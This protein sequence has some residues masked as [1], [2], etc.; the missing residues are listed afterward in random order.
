MVQKIGRSELLQ[1]QFYLMLATV[2]SIPLGIAINR[3]LTTA[4]VIVTLTAVD[5]TTINVKIKQNWLLMLPL[6]IGLVNLFGLLYTTDMKDGMSML[7]RSAFYGVLPLVV[8]LIPPDRNQTKRLINT[9]ILACLAVCIYCLVVAIW[10][11]VQTGSIINQEK[12]LDRQYYYFLN[13]EL[14]L[15]AGIS[16]IYLGLFLNLGIA[17]MFVRFF[18]NGERSVYVLV[19]TVLLHLFQ[20]LLFALSAILALFFIWFIAVL[21]LMRDVTPVKRVVV[22]FLFVG[23]SFAGGYAAFQV[24][25]LKEKIFGKEDFNLERPYIGDWNGVMIRRAIWTCAW[26]AVKD[27][28]FYGNG[29]GDAEEKLHLAYTKNKFAL[30]MANNFNAHNQYLE[31]YLLHGAIGLAVLLA[32]HF[33]PLYHSLRRRN[34]LMALFIS[35]MLLG[36]LSEAVLSVQKGVVFFSFF[37]PLLYLYPGREK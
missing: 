18:H 31:S 26:D 12:I 15:P 1:F 23:C 33:V 27:T 37:F 20:I 34:W 29:T 11:V 10:K 9:F 19:V 5:W 25:P 14:T 13:N 8:L 35:I 3:I 4:L 7:E 6:C 21:L 16:P 30:G 32:V 2:S 22:L 17:Y 28:P 36:Y 24:R